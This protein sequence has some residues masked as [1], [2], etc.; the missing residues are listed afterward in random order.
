MTGERPPED[1]PAGDAPEEP[2]PPAPAARGPE[3]TRP[4]APTPRPTARAR[5]TG[6]I[7]MG[8][9]LIVLGLAWLLD[10][11]GAVDVSVAT[12]LAALL[13]V[14][15]VALL[16]LARTGR[17]KGLIVFGSILALL[18]ALASAVDVELAGGVGQRDVRA[19]AFAD[20]R[21]EYRLAVGQLTVNL[22]DVDDLPAG[23]TV[24]D[25]SVGIGQLVVILPPDTP[26]VVQGHVG[27]GQLKLLDR[28]DSGIDVDARV[29]DGGGS[30]G[31]LRLT[32]SV[33]LGQVEVRRGR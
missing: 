4:L 6:S 10:A 23:T 25:M 20:V 22:S 15:G 24:I 12:G 8:A 3:P 33:G 30:E 28:E 32:L 9:F 1:R 13:I 17:N 5:S 27:A 18:M 26:V 19:R 7:V 21:G 29:S 14:V 31:S 16:V 11:V 2:P